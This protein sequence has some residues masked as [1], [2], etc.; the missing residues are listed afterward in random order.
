MAEIILADEIKK[1]VELQEI[2]AE[3][4]RIKRDLESMPERVKNLDDIIKEKEDIFKETEEK[5]KKLQLQHR[6]KEMDLQS[7]EQS[8]KKLKTQL[9]QIKTNKEYT[10]MEKEI[11]SSQA[12]GSLLEDMIIKILDEIDTT[13]KDL[14][15]KK[16]KFLQEKNNIENEKKKIDSHKRDIEAEL[17]KLETQRSEFIINIDKNIL[18]KYE[19]ILYAK[20]G[21]ALVP[22]AEDACSGCYMNLPPQVINEI[23]L[24][25]DLIFCG[26]CSR[27]LYCKE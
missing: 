17:K 3:I 2:D 25:K 23:K 7:K 12:D 10:A 9:Y 21:L 16:E 27:I 13:E 20:D 24:K 15:E 22:V 8:I 18:S 1:L 11:A 26:N 5:L 19:K 14:G 4:F 6:E